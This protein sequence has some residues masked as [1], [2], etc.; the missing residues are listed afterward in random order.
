[1]RAVILQDVV[2]AL[3]SC[4]IAL[5]DKAVIRRSIFQ[6]RGAEIPRNVKKKGV[7]KLERD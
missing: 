1:M 7:R 2:F 4:A 6:R 3:V 5:F